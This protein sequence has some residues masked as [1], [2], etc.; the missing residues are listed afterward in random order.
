MPAS[1]N[2][3]L[4]VAAALLA[5]DPQARFTT[6]VVAGP[7]P[8]TIV[9]VGGGDPTIASGKDSL[10]PGA[11]RLTDLAA[12]VKPHLTGPVKRVLVDNS[13]YAEPWPAG[14]TWDPR[15]VAGGSITPITPVMLDG[16]RRMPLNKDAPRYQDAAGQTATELAE[17]LGATGASVVA[18]SAPSGAKVLGEVRSPTVQQLVETA[19]MIS[20]NVLAETLAKEVAKARGKETTF[21]NATAAVRETLTE[22]GFDLTGT[23]T[24]DGSGLGLANRLNARVLSEILA[25]AAAPDGSPKADARTAK[26]RPL[27]RGLPVAGAPGGTLGGGR[28]RA[29]EA[30]AQGRGWVRAKTGTLSEGKQVNSLSG[31]VLDRD[32]RLLVFALV[33]NGSQMEQGRAALDVITSA[34]RGCGCQG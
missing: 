20:D 18:G 2:K 3:I 32:N 22:N 19:L 13:R 16:G 21:A 12:Q 9:L 4:T 6:R 15:D 24:V 5:L 33:S 7:D 1:T 31:V 23:T 14:D 10:Y 17:A 34:L 25:V 26:L 27:L 30:A 11:A 28:Y 29:G 8:E